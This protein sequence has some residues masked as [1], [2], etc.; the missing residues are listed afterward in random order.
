MVTSSKVS[1]K[2][3]ET[4]AVCCPIVWV[5]ASLSGAGATSTS[6][7]KEVHPLGEL[8]NA[9]PLTLDDS[10]E[11]HPKSLPSAQRF[12]FADD[13]Q[14]SELS[15]GLIPENTSKSTKWALKVFSQWRDAR[16][17]RY[18]D[19]PV[20]DDFLSTNDPASLNTYLS[21][22]A[23]E[24]RKV[25]GEHYPPSTIHQLLCGILRYM[26]ETN[27]SCLNYLNKQ[28]VRLKHI[29]CAISQATCRRTRSAG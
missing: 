1:R 15:K 12:D 5:C 25:T 3:E 22:F 28:D 23:V 13:E 24:A 26:K 6:L 2:M 9:K 4:S 21:K 18:P 16:N 11:P 10:S 7:W 8:S 29:G 17:Q 27:P 19:D 14:L 20:P